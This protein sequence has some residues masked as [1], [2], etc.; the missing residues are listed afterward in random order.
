MRIRVPAP[1]DDAGL[2]QAV[3]VRRER[4]LHDIG[5]KTLDHGPRLLARGAVGLV[6]LDVATGRGSAERRDDL[7]VRLLWRR[8]RHERER[9][10]RRRP[11]RDADEHKREG[12]RRQ[13]SPNTHD[14][15]SSS[16]ELVNWIAGLYAGPP[17][18]SNRNP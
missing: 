11:A 3:H 17:R 6:E 15:C 16:N 1:G 12:G 7:R 9:G 14:C 4:E 10:A 2:D 18:A 8:V 5:A 13:S